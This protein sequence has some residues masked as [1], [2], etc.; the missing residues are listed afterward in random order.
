MT[1]R[2]I[3]LLIA[4]G[5]VPGCQWLGPAPEPDVRLTSDTLRV[6]LSG[7][8]YFEV[9]DRQRTS[10]LTRSGEFVLDEMGRLRKPDGLFIEPPIMIQG[11]Y[12]LKI[13]KGAVMTRLQGSDFA[14]VGQFFL[15]RVKDPSKLRDAGQGRFLNEGGP[16]NVVRDLP[17][18]PGFGTVALATYSITAFR[19]N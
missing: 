9:H 16:E 19:Q 14:I 12:D 7:E 6:E 5:L 2:L 4:I 8:G 3:P 10:F 15:T 18:A 13:E 17:G 1:K 11:V